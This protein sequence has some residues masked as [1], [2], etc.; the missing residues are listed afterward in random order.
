MT[1]GFS[2]ASPRPN[3]WGGSMYMPCWVT[4]PKSEW[5]RI[6]WK[7][8]DNDF[9]S[10]EFMQVKIMRKSHYEYVQAKASFV[11]PEHH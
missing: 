11:V 4:L 9:L 10:R 7:V 6:Y 8:F 3:P 1:A 5:K 2:E